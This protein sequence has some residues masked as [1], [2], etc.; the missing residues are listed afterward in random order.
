MSQAVTL[1]TFPDR[2]E[3]RLRRAMM[4]LEEALREQGEALAG[5]RPRLSDLSTAVDG[6]DQSMQ[7]YRGALDGA[8]EGVGRAQDAAEIL[9][10]QSAR[11]LLLG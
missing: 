10:A 1:L 4:Q 3:Y 2:P 7:E 8:A 9:Q 11:M 6:L 5:F